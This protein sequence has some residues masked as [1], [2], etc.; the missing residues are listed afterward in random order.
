[1]PDPFHNRLERTAIRCVL[2]G[3]AA[4]LAALALPAQEN[5][6]ERHEEILKKCQCEDAPRLKDRLQKL[7]GIKTLVSNKAAS[8]PSGAPATPQEWTALQV[9]IRSYMRA[10]QFQHLTD[11]PDADL[12]NGNSDPF[13]EV[14][15]VSAGACLDEDFAHHQ[16]FH[17]ASCGAGN[18][19]WQTPWMGTA[20]FQQELDALQAEIEIIKETLKHL[21]CGGKIEIA[22]S[23][24]PTCPRFMVVVQVVTTTSVNQAGLTERS[25]RSLNN[26]QG[27]LVPLDFR[28]D[29][30]F[31]GFGEGVDAGAAAGATRGETVRSQFGHVQ[32]V[33]ASGSI[34]PGS[35]TSQP[36]QPDVM[37]LVLVG[38]PSRQAVTAQARGEVNRNFQQT[39]ATGSARLQFDLPAY[40]GGTAHR[41]LLA[42]S[43]INSNMMVGLLQVENGT[44]SLPDGSSLLLAQKECSNMKTAPAP[45]TKNP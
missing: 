4:S 15:A 25:A 30:T 39:T 13:C 41:S 20:M 37:H 23:G 36:C 28:D 26:G 1:M 16:Q 9:Q 7:E 38:G 2:I 11:F 32:A 45:A 27:I 6:G 21:G 22:G 40:I 24:P 14:P 31:E 3:V 42:N 18:W 33:A 12:F 34:E 35:C 43:L 29:G 44:P 10:L 19:S 8:V 5:L 17:N